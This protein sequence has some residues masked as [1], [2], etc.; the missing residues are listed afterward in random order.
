MGMQNSQRMLMNNKN[1]RNPSFQTPNPFNE[2]NLTFFDSSNYEEEEDEDY[3]YHDDI[4]R[5]FKNYKLDEE[6]NNKFCVPKSEI[7]A[8]IADQRK[9]ITEAVP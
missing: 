4:N 8:L 5:N 1:M 7:T 3:N 9:D 6:D 2:D